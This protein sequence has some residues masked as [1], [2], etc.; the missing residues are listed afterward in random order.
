MSAIYVY[1]KGRGTPGAITPRRADGD[2]GL[3]AWSSVETLVERM[4]PRPDDFV[5]QIDT[6][7]I[8][9]LLVAAP[10]SHDPEHWLILTR[11]SADMDAWIA[12]RDVIARSG[13]PE[14]ELERRG[15]RLTDA[16]VGASVQTKSVQ[17]WER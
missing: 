12:F 3:S 8:G 17:E 5:T 14:T 7:R 4:H 9:P 6:S 16:V 15:S 11:T 2:T 10:D 13:V 1:R